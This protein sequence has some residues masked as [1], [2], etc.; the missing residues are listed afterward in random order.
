[1][2]RNLLV[3]VDDLVARLQEETVAL[4]EQKEKEFEDFRSS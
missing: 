4:Y 2:Q 3:R 1:M